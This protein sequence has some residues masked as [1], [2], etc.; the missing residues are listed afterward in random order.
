VN[1]R[2]GVRLPADRMRVGA[3]AAVL[4]VST[5]SI[6][7][8]AGSAGASV[9]SAPV[10]PAG[11]SLV[12]SSSGYS[13]FQS[14]SCPTDDR[15]VAVGEVDEEGAMIATTSDG[16]S[17]WVPETVPAGAP[18]LTSVS[19]GS[20]TRCVAVGSEDIPGE[21]TTVAI[22][23]TRNGGKS[24]SE[25]VPSKGVTLASVSCSSGSD[26]IAVGSRV[27][28]SS[29]S[30]A[31]LSTTDGGRSWKDESTAALPELIGVSCPTTSHCVGIGQDSAVVTVDGGGK[32]AV[33][34]VPNTGA[35]IDSV[36]CGSDTTCVAV[37][38]AFGTSNPVIVSRDGGVSWSEAAS[39]DTALSVDCLSASDCIAVGMN[40]N[41]YTGL[42]YVTSNGGKSWTTQSMPPAVVEM[43]GV[44]C[45]SESACI[46]VGLSTD[47]ANYPFPDGDVIAASTTAF[48]GEVA[49]TITP[50]VSPTATFGTATTYTAMVAPLS[51]S[52]TPTGTVSFTAGSV[53]LCTAT[54]VGGSAS[55]SASDEPRGLD[56]ITAAY[57]GSASYFPASAVASQTV[58]SISCSH[59]TGSLDPTTFDFTVSLS[60]CTPGS[61]EN[62]KGTLTGSPEG[63][64]IVWEP[65][66]QT[67]IGSLAMF[68]PSQ[69]A[70]CRKGWTETD[71]T[72]TITGGTS[73]YTAVSDGV[74]IHAC[75]NSKTNRV[76][77]A[78]GTAATF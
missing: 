47:S 38:S 61:N 73:T 60:Q 74:T 16:G 56:S 40:F 26:C 78:K 32:W 9:V 52:G 4:I 64:T 13:E 27:V 44:S 49:T 19:C 57:N 41:V 46:S 63:G 8:G 45:S 71:V 22:L 72:G 25:R 53:A 35:G 36:S 42:A 65:S 59:A 33:E 31:I 69:E 23:S 62:R 50:T 12:D 3:L 67:T 29:T 77:L 66:G 76:M 54:L 70:L 30:G 18:N 37:S 10:G 5:I 68:S 55:C 58:G 51:G 28:G 15:C 7:I 21:A 39:I 14:V 11:W 48:S 75:L 1:L 43:L 6:G 24:W 20:A 17:T 2:T 34:S